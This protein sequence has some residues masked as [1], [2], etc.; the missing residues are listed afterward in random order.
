MVLKSEVIIIVTQDKHHEKNLSGGGSF[1][2]LVEILE[3]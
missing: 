1:Q 3:L 2:F